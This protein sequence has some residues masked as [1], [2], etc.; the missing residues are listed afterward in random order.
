MDFNR[1]SSRARFGAYAMLVV[2]ATLVLPG[3]PWLLVSTDSSSGVFNNTTDAT[4]N[5]ASYIGSAACEACHP[6]IAALHN[7]SGH[8]YKLQK[9]T[10]QAPTFPAEATRA[11]V[12]N[13]PTG[14]TWD[15]VS[16]IIGGY[17]RKARFITRNGNIMIGAAG[18]FDG[19]MGVETQWNL[20]YPPA[21][22]G[23]N[24]V[25]YHETDTAPK[26]YNYSCF[27]CHTTGPQETPG[28][29]E[30]WAEPGVQCEACHGPGSN[31]IPNPSARDNYVN[32]AASA[33][34]QCHTRGD[35]ENVIEASGGYIRHHE[36]WPE[37][38]GSGGHASFTCVTCHNPHASPN[39][40][41]DNAIRNP[42]TS[43]HTD[44][45]VTRFHEN[46][47][48]I[49][50]DYTESLACESCHMP[51]ATKSAAAATAAVVG[52]DGRMGDMRTHIF[53]I[54]T[55]AVD[56]NSMF[57]A[58]GKSVAKD[59]DGKAAVTLDFVCL[60]CH[61]GIGNAP[62]LTITSASAI[63]DGIHE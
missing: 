33:C 11:A 21:G 13:P 1:F 58:D 8:S 25:N 52:A 59:A 14:A 18:A 54:N 47:V 24:W 30:D 7:L 50:G 57:S 45:T 15:D 41:R 63:A 51:R 31:H 49:R 22:T 12:P 29:F 34:G 10:G 20:E 55:S 19:A 4:N 44:K 32:T 23:L 40:D 60:R 17:I 38:L 3:C 37:L 62:A 9:I 43:C 27:Q 39:Y 28:N 48:F 26:A 53:R 46:R 35:D 2:L 16:Y 36:Q 5:G 42:C 6:D 56:F 61:N